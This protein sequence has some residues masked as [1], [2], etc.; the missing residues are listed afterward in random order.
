LYSDRPSIVTVDG[1]ILYAEKPNQPSAPSLHS[2][3]NL[4]KA[5][6]IAALS[7]RRSNNVENH[8]RREKHE[9]Q[10]PLFVS[11]VSFVVPS[12]M[13]CPRYP[14]DACCSHQVKLE[15]Q[16]TLMPQL[17]ERP[18]PEN[19]RL[20]PTHSRLRL[21][22][23]A[24][25]GGL[26]VYLLI[27]Y[28]LL[29]LIWRRYERRHPA[30]ANAPRVTHTATGIPG[31]PLNIV[32]VAD[33]AGVQRALLAAGWYPADPVTL[34]SSLR[35][36]ADTVLRR[37]YDDAPVSSLYL[38][39][40]KQDLAF[41]KPVGDDPRRRHHVRFWRSAEKDEQGRPAWFG[42]AT[43]DERVGL[44]HTTGE[45]T[46]HIGPN[47]DAERDLIVADLKRIG[48]LAELSWI[49]DFH[50][51]HDGKNGGGDP[52]YTDGRLAVAVIGP[53]APH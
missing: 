35:I 25:V 3:P 9:M 8:E 11:F 51:S 1:A 23:V 37:P 18:A 53:A 27:A 47:V 26:L 14:A 29:P 7:K 6:A 20:T 24:F 36:A 41:E 38:F 33:E 21:A 42:A 5:L 49:A 22:A 48:R 50:A 40:R 28:V 19:A 52:Y 45:I 17:D 46:H 15:P 2:N 30:L 32:L 13:L 10:E 39:N 12:L 34:E 31:D 16:R 4:A 43:F 44:S